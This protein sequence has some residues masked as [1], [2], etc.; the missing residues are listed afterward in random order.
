MKKKIRK[1]INKILKNGWYVSGFAHTKH[2]PFDPS[3]MAG[4][5]TISIDGEFDT[6]KLANLFRLIDA[7]RN[8]NE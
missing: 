3:K 8:K 2:E 5:V 1:A 7:E 6:E 4:T